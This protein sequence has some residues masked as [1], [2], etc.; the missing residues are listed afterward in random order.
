[1]VEVVVAVVEPQEQPHEVWWAQP[2]MGTRTLGHIKDKVASTCVHHLPEI[3][4]T[5]SMI[6]M[7]DI[8]NM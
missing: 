8:S 1:V 2:T 4:C 5:I 3:T 6:K 7:N